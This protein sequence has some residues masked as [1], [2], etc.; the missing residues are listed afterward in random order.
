[1][2]T[3]SRCNEKSSRR[4]ALKNVSKQSDTHAGL[5]LDKYIRSL[6]REDTESRRKLVQEVAGIKTPDAYTKWFARWRQA[7]ESM[8]TQI[9]IAQTQG[10]MVVGLGAESVLETSITLHHTFGVPIIPGSA[11]KG[12][13]AHYANQHLTEKWKIGSDAHRWMF[14]DT[15]Y[16]G[17]V[18]FYDALPCP[19]QFELLRPDVMTVHHKEYYG[20]GNS[21]PAD[22]D[23]PN[24]VPFLS[25]TGQFLIALGGPK[26]WVEAGFKILEHAL[27]ELGI[28]AKT[29][30][31][32]GRME[33]VREDSP[34]AQQSET[35]LSAQF[36]RWESVQ[37]T[38]NP[39]TGELRAQ[40]GGMTASASGTSA[41]QLFACL[42]ESAQQQLKER[43]RIVADVEVEILGNQCTIKSIIPKE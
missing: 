30:S 4:N 9:R 15:T 11:L 26:D 40:H 6:D 1:M 27:R 19:N 38:R 25:V 2:T 12:L 42:P 20:D 39:G 41:Q 35:G 16:A 22:W 33:F 13:C 14:G 36:E 18:T 37:V 34:S 43:R 21:T 8:G 7:L 23:S 17:I 10:R 28:G 5:W 32:Y 24:P 3:S 29:S 31:G